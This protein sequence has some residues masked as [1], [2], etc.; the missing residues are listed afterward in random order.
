VREAE[1][2]KILKPE[3]F[4]QAIHPPRTKPGGP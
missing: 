1:L 3:P 2:S 4:P